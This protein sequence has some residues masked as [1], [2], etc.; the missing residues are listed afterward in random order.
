MGEDDGCYAMIV[1]MNHGM[2]DG[3]TYYSVVNQLSA[4][5]PVISLNA[6]RD[7]ELHDKINEVIGKEESENMNGSGIMLSF[8][9]GLLWTKLARVK[10][11]S[12]YYQINDSAIKEA[13][14]ETDGVPYVSTNDILLSWLFSVTGV[15]FHMMAINMRNRV[16]GLT[17][18][19]A[20][21]YSSNL[22][23][24]AADAKTPSLIRKS[25]INMC[26]A[27]VP[28]TPLPSTM[29]LL[30]WD[31]MWT[32]ST[33][34]ASFSKPLKIPGSEEELH[35]PLADASSM[36]SNMVFACIF[37]RKGSELGL[38]LVCRDEYAKKIEGGK[39]LGPE[40]N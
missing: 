37:R 26:R 29:E 28:K 9:T 32:M 1:S 36:F 22:L 15:N 27:S 7:V 19:L 34:W 21:Y 33:N 39:L 11:K 14:K 18:S 6:V 24:R 25:I 20:G 30:V 35:V 3:N 17:E 5:A 40:I 23:Y 13:K 12:V 8:L 38:W 2:A 31:R 10:L 16:E 4:D